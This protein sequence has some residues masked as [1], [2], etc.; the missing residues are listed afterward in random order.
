VRFL[1]PARFLRLSHPAVDVLAAL[2]HHKTVDHNRL[3]EGARER[4]THLVAV[5]RQPLIDANRHIGTGLQV[6]VGR[7][8]VVV[9]RRRII[10]LAA[11][12]RAIIRP[13]VRRILRSIVLALLAGR[14]RRRLIHLRIACL[15]GVGLSAHIRSLGIW[16]LI[17]RPGLAQSGRAG[18]RARKGRLEW[19]GR[20]E[21]PMSAASPEPMLGTKDKIQ[22]T[23]ITA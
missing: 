23:H 15:P 4:V 20:R 2:R 9:R 22:S 14:G 6:Q 13:I 1:D 8:R 21:A 11:L 3:V 18:V 12:R 16:R 19:L 5:R 7:D 17:R 10:L